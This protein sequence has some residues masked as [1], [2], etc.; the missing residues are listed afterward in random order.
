MKL[1]LAAGIYHDRLNDAEAGKVADEKRITLAN[2]IE[3]EARRLNKLTSTFLD[4]ASLRSGRV[5]LKLMTFSPRLLLKVFEVSEIKAS[6][7][8]IQIHLEAPD[9]LPKIT[10]DR[11][12]LKQVLLNL[13]GN[14]VKYNR[15]N[16]KVWLRFG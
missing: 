13:L 15:E 7:K 9:N 2:S 8:S 4:F 5:P 14:A 3:K 16:G 10:A 12:K 11:E 6:E 1:A